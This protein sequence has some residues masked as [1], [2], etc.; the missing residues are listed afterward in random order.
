MKAATAPGGYLTVWREAEAVPRY[1]GMCVL[2][3]R[4]AAG[5]LDREG[6]LGPTSAL[7]LS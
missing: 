6:V 3:T 1:R 4:P 5:G 2:G 7:L